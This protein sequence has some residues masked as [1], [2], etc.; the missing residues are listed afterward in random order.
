MLAFNVSL[1]FAKDSRNNSIN[2]HSAKA[3]KSGR[4][5]S[6]V[7]TPSGPLYFCEGDSVILRGPTQSASIVSTFAGTGVSGF[8][9][10]NANQA[11]FNSPLGL[12]VDDSG[13]IYI[14]DLQNNR[15]RKVSPTGVVSTIAGLG[16]GGFANGNAASAA[17]KFPGRTVMDNAGNIF[18]TDT[19]NYRIRKIT[20]QG[21]VSTF[22]GSG[23]RA[24][25]DG[26]NVF[27]SFLKPVGIARDKKGNFYITDMN[28]IR[29][30]DTSGNVITIAGSLTLGVCR[31]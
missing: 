22:A 29:K 14:N 20:P 21:M 8:A 18:V 28:A 3:L 27:A 11:Q 26:A 17:F 7:I 25:T 1:V 13:S 19:Y 16:I 31:W 23:N 15:I 5:Y 24:Q 30:I 2:G 4:Y 9:N 12:T 6:P 10:G